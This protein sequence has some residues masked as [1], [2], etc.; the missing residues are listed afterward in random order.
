MVYE[1]LGAAMAD[2][3]QAKAVADAIRDVAPDLAAKLDRAI[4]D[5][6]SGQ[7]ESIKMD[8][9]VSYRLEKFDGEYEPGKTPVETIEGEG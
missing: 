9:K 8:V 6:Q 1:T 3:A 7:R 5:A 4:I 2:I